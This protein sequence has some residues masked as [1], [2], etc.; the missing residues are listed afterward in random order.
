MINVARL[1]A[2][3]AY[4]P[5]SFGNMATMTGSESSRNPFRFSTKYTDD[6]T[7]MAYYGYRY[8]SPEMGRW[9]RRDPIEEQGGHGL[10]VALRNASFLFVDPV[11]LEAAPDDNFKGK[12][13]CG[14]CCCCCPV[15]IVAD[16]NPVHSWMSN[17]VEIK[18]MG[19]DL[20]VSFQFECVKTDISPRVLGE[21]G[22]AN[23][24]MEWRERWKSNRPGLNLAWKD[25]STEESPT[26][27]PWRYNGKCPESPIPIVIHDKPSVSALAWG[28]YFWRK[29]WFEI[30][31]FAVAPCWDV[32]KEKFGYHEDTLKL[33][34]YLNASQGEAVWG[35]KKKSRLVDGWP[36]APPDLP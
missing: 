20:K 24:G 15:H 14:R 26:W 18:G 13:K 28:S 36:V 9:T 10:Y 22:G 17:G 21:G 25:K 3:T 33:F 5:D 27:R 31:F 7:E 4:G 30:K 6:E 32:C 34:Q 16:A 12:V 23:C 35:G 29:V 8:Y 1:P 11:G 2:N 19:H